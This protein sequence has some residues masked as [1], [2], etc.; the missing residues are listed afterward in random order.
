M[1]R[2]NMIC[3]TNIQ[4]VPTST[5]FVLITHNILQYYRG[6]FGRFLQYIR[7]YMS[8]FWNVSNLYLFHVRQLHEQHDTRD[9]VLMRLLSIQS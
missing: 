6:L 2:H 4:Y 8:I 5:R 9:Y 1:S 7:N 3:S